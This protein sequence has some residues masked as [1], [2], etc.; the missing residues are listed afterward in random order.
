MEEIIDNKKKWGGEMK[1]E[2]LTLENQKK[3]SE[4]K[5]IKEDYKNTEPKMVVFS[6][7]MGLGSASGMILAKAIFNSSWFAVNCEAEYLL[8]DPAILVLGASFGA[9]F[10]Y[11]Y[12]KYVLYKTDKE[13]KTLE[14]E[15]QQEK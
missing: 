12:P 8:P 14:T 13:R 1:T 10:G 11:L 15:M 7:L 3:Y 2:K 6:A 9:S 5:I 4:L